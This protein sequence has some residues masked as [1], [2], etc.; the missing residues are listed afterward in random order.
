MPRYMLHVLAVVQGK[1]AA[2]ARTL[3]SAIPDRQG[4]E[5]ASAERDRLRLH[6]HVEYCSHAATSQHRGTGFV[7]QA[8][9][10]GQD[11]NK[12]GVKHVVRAL[13]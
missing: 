5:R 6:Q 13:A 3:C 9:S 2:P 8:C 4:S 12:A 1:L 10:R 7:R 11:C